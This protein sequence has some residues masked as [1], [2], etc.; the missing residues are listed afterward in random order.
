[1]RH[2]HPEDLDGIADFLIALR[3]SPQLVERKPGTFYRRGKAFLHFH[4]DPTGLHADVRLHPD[5]D[6]ERH[7]VETKAEQA[8][9]LKAIEKAGLFT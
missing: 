7:R 3:S 1:M 9:L 4:A 5:G 6:F 8:G 2:A